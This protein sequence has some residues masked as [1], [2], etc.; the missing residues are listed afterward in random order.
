MIAKASRPDFIR[1]W[2]ELEGP[3]DAAYQNS[4]E[5]LSIGAPVGKA[6]GLTRIGIHHERLPPGRRTSYPHAE[7]AEEEFA[8][9]IEGTPDA[10]IDGRLYRLKEGDAVGFPAGTGLCHSFLNNSDREARL[11]VLGEKPK[12]ENR[13]YYPCNPEQRSLRED[14]WDD[15]PPRP[16]GPHDG[17]PDC[18]K[19][20]SAI[21]PGRL[22]CIL[23]WRGSED[24][25]DHYQGDDELMQIG[26]DFSDRFGITRLGIHHGRLL[27]GRRTSYPHAE[28]LE[29]EFVFVLEGTPDAWI[30]GHLHPL[31]AGDS[32]AFPAGTGISH[33]LINNSDSGARM[34]V[35]GQRGVPGNRIWY[36]HNP[37][38]KPL[39][40]NWWDDAPKRALGGHNGRPGINPKATR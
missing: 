16:M 24:P 5:L 15:V 12:P 37:D 30:D 11:L 28:S 17:L 40:H 6:L 13:I 27:P 18:G 32:V 4:T 14:W 35:I 34:M 25:A 31:R 21:E 22:A 36:P 23:N 3:D 2:T 26:V 10:W 20:S 39:R 38:L 9:V 7:S 29:D 8:Y 33:T 19:R 1:H